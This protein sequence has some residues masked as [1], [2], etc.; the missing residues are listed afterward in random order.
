VLA[1]LELEAQA[2]RGGEHPFHLH[3][4]FFQVVAVDGAPVVPS[5]P[6]AA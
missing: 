1:K 4:F 6:T 3:G 5:S 2:G